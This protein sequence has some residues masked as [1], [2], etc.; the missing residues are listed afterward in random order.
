MVPRLCDKLKPGVL[1]REF[2]LHGGTVLSRYIVLKI[3]LFIEQVE[4]YC[5]LDTT[6]YFK[7]GTV[8]ILH[9]DEIESNDRY[10]WT[11]Q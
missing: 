10:I 2:D 8:V 7:P 1:L 5:L 9:F 3:D 4:V 6:R 11:I